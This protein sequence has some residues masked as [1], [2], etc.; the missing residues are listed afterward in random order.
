ML[1]NYIISSN[2]NTVFFTLI[3]L[4]TFDEMTQSMEMQMKII[5]SL[6]TTL[7]MISIF[8]GCTIGESSD[9]PCDCMTCNQLITAETKIVDDG[10]EFA[11]NVGSHNSLAFDDNNVPHISYYDQTSGNLKYATLDTND[12]TYPW[13]LEIADNGMV[14]DTDFDVGRHT[15]IAIDAFGQPHICY[16]DVTNSRLKYAAKIDGLWQVFIIDENLGTESG[17]WCSLVLQEKAEDA[18]ETSAMI[19]Y[20]DGNQS[21]LKFVSFNLSTPDLL[22]TIQVVDSGITYDDNIVGGTIDHGTAIAL[23]A[24][25]PVIAYYDAANGQPKIAMYNEELSAW[26]LDTLNYYVIGEPIL[27]SSSS[28]HVGTTKHD[29]VNDYGAVIIYAGHNQLTEDQY[30][31]EG[32]RNIVVN[33]DAWRDIVFSMSLSDTWSISY[34]RADIIGDIPTVANT[35]RWISI[36]VD[37]IGNIHLAYQDETYEDLRYAH[38]DGSVW[39]LEVAAAQGNVGAYTSIVVAGSLDFPDKRQPVIAYYDTTNGD[40][41]LAMRRA[42]DKWETYAVSTPNLGGTWASLTTTADGNSIGVSYHDPYNTWLMFSWLNY[43]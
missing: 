40:L 29:M 20:I 22:P 13:R 32:T 6:F 12:A 41:M 27:F 30:R 18:E 7:V 3:L 2:D 5:F 15:S 35:G 26:L 42:P 43:F 38:Y 37:E 25:Q 36:T 28:P 8:P 9:E 10:G 34:I 24:G 31:F 1:A 11:F 23:R 21:N 33:D 4:I 17:L 39:T 14:G 19:S 16:Q